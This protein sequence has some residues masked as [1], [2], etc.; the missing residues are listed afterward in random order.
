MSLPVQVVPI[1]P[2]AIEV[3]VSF[4]AEINPSTSEALIQTM[5]NLANQ[6]VS[7]VTL[8]LSTN[9]GSVQHGMNIY[10]VLKGLP[11]EL[12]THNVGNVDSIGNAIFQ[13]GTKKIA[14]KHATFM[15]HGVAVSSSANEVCTEKILAERLANVRSDQQRIANLIVEH[16]E[17]D[18]ESVN[19]FFLE[20]ET[21]TAKEAFDLGIIDQVL[22]VSI[23]QG[24]Q[25]I[26]LA[27]NR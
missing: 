15:F 27:F 4:S 10:N 18:D 22:E 3:F 1:A 6:G 13:A 5:T 2:P 9:G 11:F 25:V 14:S 26:S 16:T 8:L 7:K 19:H 23:P 21:K 20:A 12:T 24:S 17:L